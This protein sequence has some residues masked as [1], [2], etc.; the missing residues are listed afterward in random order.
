MTSA[1][2]GAP[3]ARAPEHTHACVRCGRAVPLDV[4]LCER[5]NPLGLEQP[6]TSQVHGTV[7]AALILAVV[8]LAV[9]GRVALSGI[10]PFQASV[11]EVEPA[12]AGLTVTLDVRNDGSKSGTTTCRLTR[13]ETPGI[14]A[15]AFFQTPRIEPGENRRFTTRTESFGSEPV[16]LA[17]DCQDR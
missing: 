6:A 5:C 14:G 8:L 4:S 3:A 15:S 2:P 10:G 7:A 16:A 11:V 9:V 17:I 1:P 12:A 13:R